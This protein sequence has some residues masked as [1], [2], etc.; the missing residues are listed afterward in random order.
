M[1]TYQP[2]KRRLLRRLLDICQN[3]EAYLSVLKDYEW[4]H[5]E[6]DH[7]HTARVIKEHACNLR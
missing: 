4:H 6:N 5:C 2:Y 3:V 7:F 1:L